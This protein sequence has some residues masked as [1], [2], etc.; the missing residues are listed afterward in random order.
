MQARRGSDGW[1]QGCRVGLACE[2]SQGLW[3]GGLAAPSTARSSSSNVGAHMHTRAH[4]ARAGEVSQP[5]AVRKQAGWAPKARAQVHPTPSQGCPA[6]PHRV[7]GA[8][9]LL[10]GGRKR[11][12]GSGD[13]AQGDG[14]VHPAAA[15][16][17]GAGRD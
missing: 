10:G 13:G 5:G 12:Q 11:E 8:L 15:Q 4:I 9:A 17:G 1:V 2:V 3:H 6:L 16:H 7:H 14:H